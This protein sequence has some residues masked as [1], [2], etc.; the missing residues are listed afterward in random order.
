MCL[1]RYISLHFIISELPFL[2]QAKHLK[3]NIVQSFIRNSQ[4]FGKRDTIELEYIK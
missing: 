1:G 2:T 4:I 3:I